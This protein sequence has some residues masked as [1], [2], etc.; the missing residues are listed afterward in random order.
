MEYHMS[1]TKGSSNRVGFFDLK[2]TA[3]F[4]ISKAE[5]V[6]TEIVDGIKSTT[7]YSGITHTANPV[8]D[9]VDGGDAID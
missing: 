1:I 5:N 3:P 2:E 8:G 6:S 9:D 4:G 7:T